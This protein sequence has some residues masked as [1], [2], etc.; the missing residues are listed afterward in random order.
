M[1][2]L[3]RMRMV[4]A[5]RPWLYWLMVAAIATGIAVTV[6]SAMGDVR[7]QRQAWGQAT[8]VYVATRDVAVGEALAGGVVAR[9]VPTA[10]VPPSAITTMPSDATATQH[11]AAG[12][13]VVA[14]D[15]VEASGPL[16]L[17]PRGWLAIDI[18]RTDDVPD[19]SRPLFA[20]G[21]SAVVLADGSIV[22]EHG[23]VIDVVP[24]ALAVAVPRDVAAR[25]AQAATQRVAVLAL[26]AP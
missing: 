7:R 25:V 26:T 15:I 24:G 16:A 5:R 1:R 11:V 17:V 22:A 8:T 19:T 20:V 6:A 13:I 14:T 12:E 18:P 10:V 23:I 21:D 2:W 9:D 3:P 4:L